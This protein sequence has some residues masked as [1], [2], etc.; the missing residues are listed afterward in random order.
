[1]ESLWTS[2]LVVA[3]SRLFFFSHERHCQ[4][5]RKN[6]FKIDLKNM[7]WL[8]LG[9]TMSKHHNA[10]LEITL[11]G[12]QTFYIFASLYKNYDIG[13]VAIIFLPRYGV[14]VSTDC[15][16]SLSDAT[17]FGKNNFWKES[18]LTLFS[19]RLRTAKP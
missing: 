3:T 10:L 5:H 13:G 19:L 12:T 2:L 11:I 18:P 14:W 17:C 1:M 7:L 6:A 8:W 15:S 9:V 16:E 4:C